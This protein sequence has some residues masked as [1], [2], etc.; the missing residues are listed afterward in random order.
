[1]VTSILVGVIAGLVVFL[2]SYVI[3]HKSEKYLQKKKQKRIKKICIYHLEKL[4]ERLKPAKKEGNK[5]F[6]SQTKLNEI[7]TAWYVYDM[8]LNHVDVF[9]PEKIKNTMEFFD[10]YSTNI[11][12]IKSRMKQGIM[13]SLTIGTFENLKKYL[14][15]ALDELKK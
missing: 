13:G 7:K 12:Q 9:D 15:S 5:V 3:T 11:E 4:N 10:N 6:F 2:I 14:Q 1:M 8:L